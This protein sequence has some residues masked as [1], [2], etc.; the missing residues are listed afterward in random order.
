MT[1]EE[2]LD[3]F[4]KARCIDWEKLTPGQRFKITM[5]IPCS[6]RCF[7]VGGAVDVGPGEVCSECGTKQDLPTSWDMIPLEL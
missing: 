1:A 5:M 7:R 3:A 4:L 6:I 2:W